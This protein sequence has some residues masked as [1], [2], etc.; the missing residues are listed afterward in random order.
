MTDWPMDPDNPRIH[1][2]DWCGKRE[3]WGPTWEWWGTWEQCV[4]KACSD[5]CMQAIK[6]HTKGIRKPRFEASGAWLNQGQVERA[7]LALDAARNQ[8]KAGP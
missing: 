3:P 1:E 6:P 4:F 2:C 5:A 7:R 8:T